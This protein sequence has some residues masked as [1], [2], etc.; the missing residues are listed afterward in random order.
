M[1]GSRLQVAT[2]AGAAKDAVTSVLPHQ[3]TET[4]VSKEV[5]PEQKY[6]LAYNSGNLAV[7]EGEEIAARVPPSDIAPPTTR[8]GEGVPSTLEKVSNTAALTAASAANT[9]V[10]AK[11]TGK[12]LR[13]L[14][15]KVNGTYFFCI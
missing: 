11:D 13:I 9:A 5:R 12:F 15:C 10:A 8:S 7:L 14:D 1:T 4:T 2:L 3:T 6:D